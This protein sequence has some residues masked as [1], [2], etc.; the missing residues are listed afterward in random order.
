MA[1]NGYYDGRLSQ[2]A[3][4][5]NRSENAPAW[6][7]GVVLNDSHN[8][9]GKRLPHTGL[10]FPGDSF[11]RQK[12]LAAKGKYK[13][14]HTNKIDVQPITLQEQIIGKL[15]YPEQGKGTTRL[16]HLPTPNIFLPRPGKGPGPLGVMISLGGHPGAPEIFGQTIDYMTSSFHKK[17]K[18]AGVR[19]V[20]LLNG[21]KELNVL[22]RSF[23]SMLQLPR[24][25]S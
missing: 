16:I 5:H 11:E 19:R 13:L 20:L 4:T 21:I 7:I 12:L 15:T 17:D 9:D 14:R 2:D 8:S 6:S 24:G 18:H 23:G 10:V 22:G 3:K 1:D 25:N